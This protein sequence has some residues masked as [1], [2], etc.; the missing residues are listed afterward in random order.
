MR[1]ITPHPEGVRLRTPGRPADR[2]LDIGIFIAL[3]P[4]EHHGGAELQADRLARELARKGHRVHIFCRA[5]AGRPAVENRD[6]V[7]IHRRPV[8]PVPGLRLA[9]EVLLGAWQAWRARPGVLLCFMTL[10]SGLI[11]S[12][13][14]R[15]C[16]VPWIV[17]Q[18]IEGE[19]LLD[20]A[21]RERT[22]AFWI[23][24]RAT[25][26]WLQ[27]RSFQATLERE[28]ARAGRGREWQ[29]LQPRLRVLGN[30]VDVAPP[31]T[32]AVPPW[33]VLFVGRLE[34]QKDLP[35][36][37]EAARR[38]PECEVWIAGTG[39]LRGGLEEQ[40]RGTT[41]RFLGEQAHERIPELLA[42]SRALVLCSVQEGVPNVVLE[43]LA[44]GRPVIATPVGAIPELVQDGVHGR[45]VPVGDPE[46][47]AAALR[48]VCDDSVWRAWAG[49]A[50][51]A[52]ARFDWPRL[53][54]QVEDELTAITGAEKTP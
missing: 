24:R 12:V 16:G 40:A 42:A 36:L 29:R 11:G 9:L 53:V 10:N 22:L 23:N 2:R 18:R 6:G 52:V 41:V 21:P 46:R 3:L 27:A 38:V 26:I 17:W 20:A 33:R 30:G 54:Q 31:R 5:Q 47:L 4:P 48:E 25:A 28:Y 45:L 49:Q 43:A 37:L 39:S 50:R 35:T 34:S 32:E 7:V 51:N 8:V 13:A 19:A 1:H 14:G 44:H 15:W